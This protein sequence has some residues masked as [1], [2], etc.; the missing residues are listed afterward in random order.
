MDCQVIATAESQQ[1]MGT[2]CS[3]QTKR[4]GSIRSQTVHLCICLNVLKMGCSV[5]SRNLQTSG[6]IKLQ[7]VFGFPTRK[8][9]FFCNRQCSMEQCLNSEWRRVIYV[10]LHSEWEWFCPMLDLKNLNTF[11]KHKHFQIA[12]FFTLLCLEI[13]D[14]KLH[15]PTAR[16]GFLLQSIIIIIITSIFKVLLWA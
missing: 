9:K 10:S 14:D 8:W 11:V 12:A 7:M 1:R 4:A 2:S 13:A 15:C 5:F 16:L 6:F 3:V